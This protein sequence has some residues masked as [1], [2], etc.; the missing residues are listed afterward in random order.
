MNFE[1][2]E[3]T[4]FEI[5]KS[6]EKEIG[7]EWFEKHKFLTLKNWRIL[8][9][10]IFDMANDWISPW[11]GLPVNEQEKCAI[12]SL[13]TNILCR[14]L[15]K[16]EPIQ[17]YE[18]QLIGG[19]CFMLAAKYFID[20]LGQNTIYPRDI[21][22]ICD[23]LY[24]HQQVISMERKIVDMLDWNLGDIICTDFFDGF[25]YNYPPIVDK[26][27]R[28]CIFWA[29]EPMLFCTMKPSMMAAS[30]FLWCLEEYPVCH[31]NFLDSNIHLEGMDKHE[32]LLGSQY[33]KST[34][35]D[36]I[37][38]D[39]TSSIPRRNKIEINSNFFWVPS[40]LL[41]SDEETIF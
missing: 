28:I 8:I 25:H 4:T 21:K 38:T 32:L 20:D 16:C 22:F 10:W 34:V 3:K 37:L 13:T 36:L 27:A 9:G 11:L 26:V 24:T 7:F 35:F 23:D 18:F 6:R 12:V 29:F 33:L 41:A 2:S 15:K 40:Q 5:K 19:C 39:E 30:A 1:E 17:K 31:Q 14:Y